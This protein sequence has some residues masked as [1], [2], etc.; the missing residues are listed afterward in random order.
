M[1]LAPIP[2]C[3]RLLAISSVTSNDAMSSSSSSGFSST[4]ESARRAAQAAPGS[5]VRSQLTAVGD[6]CST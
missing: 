5:A 2:E 4:V 6:P 1:P 3:W